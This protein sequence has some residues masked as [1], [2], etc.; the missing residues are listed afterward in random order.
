MGTR[1]ELVAAGD[2]RELMPVLEEAVREIE[3][4]HAQLSRFAADSLLCHIQRTAHDRPVRLDRST[5]ELFAAAQQ[6]YMASGGA[7]DVTLGS[8]SFHLNPRD[9]SIVLEKPG[10]TLDL[11]AIAKGHAIDR[12]AAILRAAGVTSALL[13]G[14]TSSVLA[15]GT[16]PD[17]DAWRVGLARG[18]RLPWVEL[19][20]AALSVSRPFSHTV[21]GAAHIRDPRSAAPVQERRFA[22]VIGPSA[23]LADAWSTA[24]AVIGERPRT[25][26]DEWITHIE[27]E[28][29]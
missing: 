13:H 18:H 27:A 2:E 28:H 24:L 29:E 23:T 16:P 26:G 7:F 14:G 19:R 6:V 3:V 5:F 21:D 9:C 10:T 12:A 11:G 25:L 17:A 20:A 22:L 4:L 1:F 15:I 8:G